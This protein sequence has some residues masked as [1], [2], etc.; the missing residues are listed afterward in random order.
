MF[1]A[2]L[3]ENHVFAFLVDDI[4]DGIFLLP[5]MFNH[6]FITGDVRTVHSDVQNVV[7]SAAAIHGKAVLPADQGM[8][9]TFTFGLYL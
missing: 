3:D 5:L 7:A 9:K 6:D 8:F 2:P 1:I 4:R